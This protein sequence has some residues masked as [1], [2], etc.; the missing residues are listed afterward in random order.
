MS[1]IVKWV[2]ISGSWRATSPEIEKDVRKTARDIVLEG[3]GIVTGGA[4]NVDYQATDEVLS[5]QL[6]QQVKVFLPTSLATYAAHYRKRAEEGVI[7][8]E[9]AESL[10]A[11][12]TTL[13]EQNPE[14]IVENSDNTF[15][16]TTT[17]YERNQAV[18]DASDELIA[19][20]VNN[21]K[22]TQDTIDKAKE[23]GIPVTIHSYK[24]EQ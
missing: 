12:L 4:L 2:G 20:Q 1:G 6:P 13:R 8:K 11:Q 19:F 9:Q 16:D 23:K 17:Y 24:V 15:V 21:S 10:I 3:N 14:G 18:V 5:L 7:T 22:G